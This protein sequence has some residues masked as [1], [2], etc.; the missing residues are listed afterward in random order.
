MRMLVL[1]LL[2]AIPGVA[3]PSNPPATLR[4]PGAFLLRERLHPDPAVL[5]AVR[6][7]ADRAMQAGPFSVMEKKQTPP[8][9]DKHDFMSQAPYWWP[10]PATPNGLP[11]VRRDGET[12][13][14]ESSISDH[15]N[16]F[17]VE[18]AVH[19]LALG[20][21]FTGDERYASRA[22]LLLRTWFLDPATRMNPNLNYAQAIP[23]ITTGRGIGLIGMRAIPLVLDGIT[24]LSRSP[25]LTRADREGLRAWFTSYLQWLQNSPNGRAEAAAKNNHGSW[26]DQ[27]LAGIAIYL[28]DTDLARRVI[29]AAKRERIAYQIRADGRE[30]LELARTKSFSYSVFNL[31]ALMRL[32]QEG[33][34]AGVDLWDYRAPD[35]GSI[36][37]ALNFLL[38]YAMGEKQWP[39]QSL[40]GVES[41]ALT[42]PLLLAAIRYRSSDY[43]NDAE[44][45]E[46]HPAPDVLLL[47]QDAQEKLAA[48]HAK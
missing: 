25:S 22:V 30:P 26:Y 27:Q 40:N 48:S 12:N 2:V 15:A 45:L 8:S 32:A 39:Y 21:C 37:A 10:N 18:D 24:L 47:Q 42:E 46:K 1:V 13:P 33:Q 17:R 38:P 16:L 3:Q 36:R 14:Q 7:E 20:Y 28:G 29:E 19:A 9:G 23:G 43:L 35:G 31:M 11:Y 6:E 5:Q 34:R 44:K 41:G 4:L